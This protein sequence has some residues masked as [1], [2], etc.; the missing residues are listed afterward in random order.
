[1]SGWLLMGLPGALYAVG[2][3]QVWVAVGLALGTLPQ[4]EYRRQRLRTVTVKSGDSLTLPEYFENRFGDKTRILRTASGHL[5]HHLFRRVHRLRPGG[6]RQAVCHRV[7]P[8][9]HAAM[10]IGVLVILLYTFLGGF[11]AVC[12]TDLSRA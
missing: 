2:P 1:M 11:M 12:W 5:Y 8:P 9:L 7:S 3:G 10:S 6:G 4:L